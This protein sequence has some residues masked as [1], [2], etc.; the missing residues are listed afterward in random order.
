MDEVLAGEEVGGD[1]GLTAVVAAV[2]WGEGEIVLCNHVEASV[3]VS[4]G[5]G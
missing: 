2:G 3:C 5:G 4:L 1:S